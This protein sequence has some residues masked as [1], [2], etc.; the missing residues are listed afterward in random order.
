M[1]VQ[2]PRALIPMET[3]YPPPNYPERLSEFLPT[4]HHTCIFSPYVYDPHIWGGSQ[5]DKLFPLPVLRYINST[6]HI[7]QLLGYTY[8]CSIKRGLHILLAPY[9]HA[10]HMFARFV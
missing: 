4:L 7:Y 10:M 5:M 8:V 3:I 9:M 1:S 6:A 2:I